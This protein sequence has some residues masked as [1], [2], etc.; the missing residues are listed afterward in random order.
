MTF[1]LHATCWMILCALMSHII[2]TTRWMTM[3]PLQQSATKT[4]AGRAGSDSRTSW[5]LVMCIYID[6][7]SFLQ[8]IKQLILIS[9]KMKVLFAD[10]ILLA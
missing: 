1:I 7:C 10:V 4:A 5:L 3:E 9:L 8:M 6:I 2:M